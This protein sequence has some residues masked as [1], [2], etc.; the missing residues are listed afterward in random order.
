MI[1]KS[2]RIFLLSIATVLLIGLFYLWINSP[3]KLEPLSDASGKIIPHAI[4]EKSEIEIGGIRQGFFIRSENPANPVIL[5]LHGG[6]GS[7]E[8]PMIIPTESDE[9][10]EKYF[11]VCYWD[12]RGAGMSYSKSIDPSTM[13]IDQMVQDTHEMT[14]YL[15]RRFKKKKIFIMGHSWGT[16]LGV[17]TV[18]RYPDDY[19][20]YFGI[21][22]VTNQL[23]SERLAYDY[24]LQHATEIGD[25]NNI[26]KLSKFHK[27]A[28]DF[29]NRKYLRS[30]RSNL[31]EEYGIGIMHK[32][33]SMLSIAKFILLFKGYTLSEKMN[34]I[35]G[36]SFSS[37][38]VFPNMISD[39][40]FESSKSFKVPVC[41][42]SGKYDYQVSYTLAKKYLD[43]IKAP[44]K[45]FYT[46]ENSAHSPNM[47]ETEQFVYT[48]RAFATTK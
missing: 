47:E 42:I 3:G 13:T 27:L 19:S 48:I 8:L 35:R 7:P 40:L 30:V 38:Y 31:M 12:Q 10:L 33:T 37:K 29:P 20:A 14:E 6:P 21:G 24:M 44:E 11:T 46:F 22:Q 23:E 1:K 4:A 34:Y 18:E 28:P 36:M 16:Y 9:R 41:L 2:I 32:N 43:V 25:K 5:Y 26:A 45:R 39:N 17:K 15:Q